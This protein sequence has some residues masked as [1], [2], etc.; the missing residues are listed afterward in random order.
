MEENFLNP[1]FK[2]F[3]KSELKR[4]YAGFFLRF[5]HEF[6]FCPDKFNFV[7]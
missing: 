4:K 6:K 1:N 2:N 5:G 7:W 3:R